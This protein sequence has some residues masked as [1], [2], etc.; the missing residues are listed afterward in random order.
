[1]VTDGGT[2]EW[3]GILGFSQGARMA[4]STLLENQL[5]REERIMGS[6]AGVDWRFGV[7][8]AGSGPP[9]CLS[10]RSRGREGFA[11]F[12]KLVEKNEVVEKDVEIGGTY[13]EKRL[14]IPT[15]H[16][17]G[18]RD[19]GLTSY[20]ELLERYTV[21]KYATLVEWDG[22]HRL[23]IQ[24]RDVKRFTETINELGK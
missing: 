8:I 3:I 23:P 5:R 10:E 18:L 17:H 19:E 14:C 13:E 24:S 1:M 20:R 11:S 7:L 16:V 15:I 2:G 21:R 4:F 22:D 12:T 6:F 9:F